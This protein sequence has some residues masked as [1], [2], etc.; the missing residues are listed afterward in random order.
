[1]LTELKEM[2]ID[3]EGS[4]IDNGKLMQ[5]L[6]HNKCCILTIET[7]VNNRNRHQ[8]LV[9]DIILRIT[10]AGYDVYDVEIDGGFQ[11]N[12]ASTMKVVKKGTS[13]SWANFNVEK[14]IPARERYVKPAFTNFEAALSL[15]KVLFKLNAIDKATAMDL[16]K[17]WENFNPSEADKSV[18]LDN[19]AFWDKQD[20][21]DRR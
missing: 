10:S 12:V 6:H 21:R 2:T 11:P 16:G 8:S 5:Y 1:M 3:S 4:A 9:N 13:R 18:F 17:Y 20:K 7:I 19:K 15:S 14:K